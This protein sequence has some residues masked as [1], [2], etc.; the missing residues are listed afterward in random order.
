MPWPHCRTVSGSS[1]ARLCCRLFDPDLL[2]ACAAA[3]EAKIALVPAVGDAESVDP[4]LGRQVARQREGA[5]RF[6][7]DPAGELRLAAT[8]LVVRPEEAEGDP[9]G[10]GDAARE[11]GPDR[12]LPADQGG[13]RL[14]LRR[15]LDDLHDLAGGVAGLGCRLILG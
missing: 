15:A 9:A 7:H 10:R 5:V 3:A 12:D 6:Y 14:Y 4:R 11:A 8:P 13:P 1:G 2:G